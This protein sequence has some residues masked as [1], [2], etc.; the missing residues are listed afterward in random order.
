V[1][2]Q[3]TGD[4]VRSREN[5]GGLRILFAGGV[6][7]AVLTGI[8]YVQ[9][10]SYLRGYASY[11]GIPSEFTSIDNWVMTRGILALS[12]CLL[13]VTM[14]SASAVYLG[15]LRI[16]GSKA[17][18][19]VVFAPIVALYLYLT[20]ISGGGLFQMSVP[21]ALLWVVYSPFWVSPAFNRVLEGTAAQSDARRTGLNWG[22]LSW[23][24]VDDL[25]ATRS[26]ERFI[27][28]VHI[29]VGGHMSVRL[30]LA[31]LFVFSLSWDLGVA[32]A[33][34]KED[35]LVIREAEPLVMLLRNADKLV[36][37]PLDESGKKI[38]QDIILIDLS[39][40]GQ[41]RFRFERVGPLTVNRVD[42]K[43]RDRATIHN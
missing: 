20:I 11:F 12:T 16:H 17:H 31:F 23:D 4:V 37:A 39:Q 5:D 30:I 43:G 40:G 25:L 36:C 21:T 41:R 26:I 34:T 3:D 15:T 32:S 19:L 6:A 42:P 18:W 33:R 35:F 9:A 13:A 14:I 24:R 38:G 22:N 28:A 7:L 29:F 27:G 2:H 8:V 1:L 10:L